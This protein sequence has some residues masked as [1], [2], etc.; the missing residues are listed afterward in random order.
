VRHIVSELR[1]F[2]AEFTLGCHNVA[3]IL[4]IAGA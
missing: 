1:P 3:P 4:L 2:A